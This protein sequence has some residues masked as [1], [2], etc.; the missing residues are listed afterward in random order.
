M[1]ENW[2]LQQRQG[3]SLDIK[4]KMSEQRI[5]DFYEHFNGEVYIAFSGGKD[6]TVLLNLV[7]KFYPDV[8]AVFID[9]G[10]EYPEIRDFVKNTDNVTFFKPAKSFKTVIEQY[11]YPVVSKS[12]SQY[13]REI[14]I[15]KPDS[16]TYKLRMDGIT[17]KGEK[18]YI[19][20]IPEKWKYLIDA[21]FKI[22]ERC[23]YWLKKR[24]AKRYEKETGRKAF[25]GMMA[26]DS[27]SRL[28]MYLQY[29]CNKFEGNK[30]HSNPLG[31]WLE[32]DIWDYHKKFNIP[33]SKIYDMGW[34]RTGCMFC[35]FGCH[36]EPKP[37]RFQRM[38][39]T[40]PKQYKYCMEN[41][42]L[43]DILKYIKIDYIPI[44]QL[45]IFNETGC[46]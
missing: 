35:M 25:I 27:R 21:P 32:N 17:S 41:L 5:K 7:R 31:F 34:D 10:L 12:V 14:R 20:K 15:S 6:S 43:K 11:G 18:Q 30:I 45:E 24:P 22:S 16:A 23:C 3:Q 46:E 8:P 9:T 1:V 42:G 40:H 19:C 4:I 29:G 39:I 44:K 2:Q 33:H 37:N 36:L 13:I 26:S 28:S 38:A